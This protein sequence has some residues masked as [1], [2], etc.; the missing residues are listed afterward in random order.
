MPITWHLLTGEYPPECGGV[1]DYTAA[2]A[3][4]LA[5]AGDEVHV[6]APGSPALDRRVAAHALPDRFG[7]GA[8][9]VLEQGIRERP[10]VVL[11][12]Y[13]PNALGFRGANLSF[14]LWFS[15]LRRW[16]PDVRVMFHEAFFYFSWSH[17]WRRANAL[18]L[19]QR[20]M[21]AALLRGAHAAYQSTDNWTDYLRPFG[22]I[23]RLRTIPVPSGLPEDATPE[24]IAAVRQSMLGTATA[25]PVVGHFGTYGAH[26]ADQLLGVLPAILRRVPE[27]RLA[28]IGSGGD[29]FLARLQVLH[30]HLAERSWVS[31]RLPRESVPAALRACD[32]LVQPYPDGVTTRRT[33]VMAGLQN[34]VPTVSTAGPLTE[35]VWWQ[36]DAV[37]LAPAADP[38]ACA[39]SV[40]ALLTDADARLALGRRGR[41]AYV[42]HFSIE[43]TVAVLRG[44]GT[45]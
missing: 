30:P 40:A 14:C 9:R 44:G 20:P 8:R 23:E 1:G 36:T 15:R 29:R 21:A 12:Q 28:L 7:S 2:L 16:H 22:P 26:V 45:R 3:E 10:G 34:A 6:W 25:A 33:S 31:G 42:G 13:V 38:E 32:L 39:S 27:A 4:A 41:A 17:P 37:A 11:L 43:H 5:G 24:A 19:V 35:S 18:A